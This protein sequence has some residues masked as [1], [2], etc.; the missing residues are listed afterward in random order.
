MSMVVIGTRICSLIWA[1]SYG[2]IGLAQKKSTDFDAGK[3][4]T[5]DTISM[6]CFKQ[7]LTQY[8]LKFCR[9]F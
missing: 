4:T 1:I 2:G 3:K 6:W 7:R 8:I 9:L 5:K